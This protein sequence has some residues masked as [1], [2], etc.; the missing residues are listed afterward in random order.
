MWKGSNELQLIVTC[1]TYPRTD[2]IL[3]LQSVFFYLIFQDSE[4]EDSK[5]LMNPMGKIFNLLGD[6]VFSLCL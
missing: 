5:N 6:N 3:P 2:L 4:I 1:F